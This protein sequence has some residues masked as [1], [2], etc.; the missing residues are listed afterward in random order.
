[1]AAFNSSLY[2]LSNKGGGDSSIIIARVTRI[3]LDRIDVNDQNNKDFKDLGEWGG[4]GCINFSILYSSKTSSNKK[5][6]NLIAKPLF[7]N[8]KQ[9]PLVGEIVQIITGPSDGLNDLK[10]K[11][12]YYYTTPFNT[13]NSVHHNAFP[14]L[15]EYA[16]FVID[17]KVN[18]DQVS[19][20]NTQGNTSTPEDFP[21]GKTFKEKNNIK[22]LLPFE[23][24][25]MLEGR[26]GQS[27]RFGSTIPGKERVNIWSNGSEA[28]DPITIIRNYQGN[29]S[30]KEGYVPTVENIN[31]DGSSI[32][33]CHNQEINLQ[34]IGKFPLDTFKAKLQITADKTIPLQTNPIMNDTT[35]PRAQDE[36]SLEY[37]QLSDN[38]I[39]NA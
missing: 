12:D 11:Q 21:L 30:V 2:G 5:Y 19:Q 38:S 4:V 22:D 27:I 32:Y 39:K 37:A 28:G 10:S 3:I 26:W 23:G 8:I 29:Q 34:D 17:N 15:K 36:K 20:G 35:S 1:M 9:Y 6:P 14:D 24:D 7:S 31:T 25:I 13:W 18:Y 33:L 16:E